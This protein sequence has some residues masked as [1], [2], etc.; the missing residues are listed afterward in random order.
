MTAKDVEKAKA[1]DLS[2]SFKLTGKSN[3]I[4]FDFEGKIKKYN[5]PEEVIDEFCPKRLVPETQG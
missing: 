3:T 2:E 1:Q 5:S 4:C